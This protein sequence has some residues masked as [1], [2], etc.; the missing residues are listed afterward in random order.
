MAI[1][2]ITVEERYGDMSGKS[3]DEIPDDGPFFAILA[4]CLS[5]TMWCYEDGAVASFLS[6]AWSGFPTLLTALQLI[7]GIMMMIPLMFS[8]VMM[9]VVIGSWVK[10]SKASVKT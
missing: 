9:L 3:P 10:A 7:A 8:L 5:L 2:T 4:V 6:K 1:E